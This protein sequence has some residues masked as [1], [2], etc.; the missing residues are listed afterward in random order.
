MCLEN[1]FQ[2]LLQWWKNRGRMSGD[3]AYVKAGQKIHSLFMLASP[4]E[5][6]CLHGTTVHI[7]VAMIP[8]T[9]ILLLGLQWW[10]I[11]RRQIKQ[12]LTHVE[13]LSLPIV[14]YELN[15]VIKHQDN[16]L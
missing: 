8:R 15:C 9:L 10:G 14:A 2:T 11:C 4:F 6:K 1:L 3:T 5:K 16:K 13:L 7:S 12:M